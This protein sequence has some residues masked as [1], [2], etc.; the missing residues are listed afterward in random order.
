MVRSAAHQ[1]LEPPFP[2]TLVFWFANK[3]ESLNPHESAT[4]KRI[5]RSVVAYMQESGAICVHSSLPRNLVSSAAVLPSLPA[6][7]AWA[8]AGRAAPALATVAQHASRV[9]KT[10]VKAFM[11]ELADVHW[12]RLHR[13]CVGGRRRTFCRRGPKVSTASCLG[14]LMPTKT[15][16]F[17]MAGSPWQRSAETRRRRSARSFRF[18]LEYSD[19]RGGPMQSIRPTP[20]HGARSRR[21]RRRDSSASTPNGRYVRSSVVPFLPTVQPRNTCS[22]DS[23]WV[24]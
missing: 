6:A 21:P 17:N 11:A 15:T 16:S 7:I 22:R 5:W 23:L 3:S 8:L 14:P 13:R 10:P 20:A 24:V 4:T 1:L 18:S 12:R 2:T 19:R 9:Y